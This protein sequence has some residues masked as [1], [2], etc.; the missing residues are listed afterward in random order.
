[1]DEFFDTSKMSLQEMIELRDSLKAKMEQEKNIEARLEDQKLKREDWPGL[2]YFRRTTPLSDP[3]EEK[4]RKWSIG[5]F[6]LNF[7]QDV[8]PDVAK[9][10]ATD[11]QRRSRAYMNPLAIRERKKLRQKQRETGIPQEYPKYAKGGFVETRGEGKAIRHKKTR[12]F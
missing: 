3:S 6:T 12:M 9:A 7:N 10:M 4:V 1:M 8:H 2:D 11:Q 5:N